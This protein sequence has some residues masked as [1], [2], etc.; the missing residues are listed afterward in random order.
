MEQD[1]LLL[2]DIAPNAV[3]EDIILDPRLT[4]AEFSQYA[5]AIRATGFSGLVRQSTLYRVPT[6][7][8]LDI[9]A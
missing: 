1:D 5:S 4:P 6:F 2:F 7:P 3:V 9:D 8:V